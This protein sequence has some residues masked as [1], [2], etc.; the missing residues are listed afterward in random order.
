MYLCVMVSM[1]P[2]SKILKFDL[3]CS[4]MV[5]FSVLYVFAIMKITI[6][7]YLYKD[8]RHNCTGML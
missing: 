1:L 4:D 2:F 3:N 5:V 6:K 7:L 8:E